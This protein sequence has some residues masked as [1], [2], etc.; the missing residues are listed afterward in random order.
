MCLPFFSLRVVDKQLDQLRHGAQKA[1]DAAIREQMGAVQSL[2]WNVDRL[3][4]R[5]MS[6]ESKFSQQEKVLVLSCLIIANRHTHYPL[7][8]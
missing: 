1:M 6:I 3:H 7:E 5:M 8:H 4:Q 2:S